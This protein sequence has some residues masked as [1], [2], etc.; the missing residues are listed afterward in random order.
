MSRFAIKLKNTLYS[1]PFL[2]PFLSQ[3][4]QNKNF[5]KKISLKFHAV[6]NPCKILEKPY[7]GPILTQTIFGFFSQNKSYK[8]L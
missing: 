6:I 3:I 4:P 5:V 8:L 2:L 7:F 1:G